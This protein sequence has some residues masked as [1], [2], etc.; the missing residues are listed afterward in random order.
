MV[1]EKRSSGKRVE[2]PTVVEVIRTEA[3]TVA[4]D[5]TVVLDRLDWTVQ[6]EER[7]VI[8]GPNGAGKTSLLNMLSTNSHPTR[9][10]VSVLGNEL[11]LV[12]VFD[13]RPLIGVVSPRTTSLI[14]STEPVRDVVMTSAWAITGRWRESYEDDDLNRADE[15]MRV[16][17]VG[18]LADRAFSTLSD[19]E[20]KRALIARALMPN[21]ELLLLDEPATGLDL[22]AREALVQR[23]SV[24]AGDR[25]APVQVMITHHVE[26][27]PA[28]FTHAMLLRD[29]QVVA[30]GQIDATLTDE[31]LTKTFDIPLSVSKVFSRYWAFAV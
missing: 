10:N 21:P 17:G 19:G 28:G 27:I 9:G 2:L 12:D 26:E 14:P 20:K 8:L 7:W 1:G 11:G 25:S 15:L 24:L 31:N 30:A 13:L 18:H 29:G 6:E 16:M 22:G 4:F 5:G 3:A 23:L